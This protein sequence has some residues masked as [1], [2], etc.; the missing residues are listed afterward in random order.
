MPIIDVGGKGVFSVVN[1][2]HVTETGTFYGYVL[3]LS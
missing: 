2:I 1:V 3:Y